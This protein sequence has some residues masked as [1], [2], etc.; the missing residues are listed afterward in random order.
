MNMWQSNHLEW[1]QDTAL[2][3]RTSLLT[4]H[5][6]K[7]LLCNGTRMILI[8]TTDDEAQKQLLRVDTSTVASTEITARWK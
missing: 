1:S 7:E 2:L 4:E 3:V 8:C 6:V 5:T